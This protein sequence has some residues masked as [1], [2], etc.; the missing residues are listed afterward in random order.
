MLLYITVLA[1]RLRNVLNNSSRLANKNS[2]TWWY[3]LKT[4]W[5][6]FCKKSWRCL[7]DDLNTSSEDVLKTF[8][9]DVFKTFWRRLKD[10]FA[11][12]LEDV[13]KT[14]WKRLEDVL[15]TSWRR[16]AKTSILILTRRLKT[17]DYGEYICLDQDVFKTSWRCLL[18]MKTKDVFKTSSSRRMFSGILVWPRLNFGS[19]F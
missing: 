17:Y 5:R 8:L 14:S 12:H 2:L 16:M 6:Y 11:R 13:L 4:S 9:Q 3:V 19:F 15:K 1:V 10:V 7:G 18:K